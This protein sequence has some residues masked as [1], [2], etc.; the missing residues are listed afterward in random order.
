MG[1]GDHVR[2]RG[3]SVRESGDR[4]WSGTAVQQQHAAVTGGRGVT[5]LVDSEGEPV[6][7]FEGP[8]GSHDEA[9]LADTAHADIFA[10][11]FNGEHAAVTVEASGVAMLENVP[12]AH[13]DVDRELYSKLPT[14]AP[15]NGLSDAI[16]MGRITL[17]G[18]S[19]ASA[20]TTYRNGQ[21][22]TPSASVLRS[23]RRASATGSANAMARIS[24]A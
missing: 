23:P 21:A 16:T 14:S 18:P 8:G 2:V 5:L 22:R 20:N 19:G 11:R 1:R 13:N 10:V 6:A 9:L 7:Q 4:A 15:G 12:Y 24:A 3:Q 17:T